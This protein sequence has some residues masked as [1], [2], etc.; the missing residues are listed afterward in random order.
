MV[1][2]VVNEIVLGIAAKVKAIYKDKG[3]YP[4][5]TNNEEQGLEKPCFFIK[6]IDGNESREIGLE[7]K[8]YKDLLNIV[9]IGYTL[10]G[11]TEILNDMIDNLYELEYIELSD[12]SLI[13]AIKLHQKVE[14][15]VL[16][17][18]IDYNLSI[19]KD[20]DATIKMNDYN[21]SGEVKKDENI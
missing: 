9:I 12:K 19:K 10:D 20:D 13:R 8:F 18:F 17:F 11:N 16:H 2:S 14:D 21:L 5:Y 4:I 15:G 7:N 1:K 6:V 3:D